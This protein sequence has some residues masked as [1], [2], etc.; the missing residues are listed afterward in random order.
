MD[1]NVAPPKINILEI[2]EEI[3]GIVSRYFHIDMLRYGDNQDYF[4]VR[5]EGH[6]YSENSEKA[7]GELSNALLS[8]QITPLFRIEESQQIIYLI[9]E[10]EKKKPANPLVNL[11]LFILTILSVTFA[12][13][14][15]NL[16]EV[17]TQFD[18][19]TLWNLFK[20]GFPFT[21]SM[22]GILTAH[23]FGIILPDV[24]IKYT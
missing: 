4:L 15:Y 11:L 24:C 23:E 2:S 22:L 19:A 13:V 1:K 16:E 12:G 17:P 18:V 20:L 5:Y 10:L 14:L 6:L 21:V 7:Y 8:Y 9:P 3:R